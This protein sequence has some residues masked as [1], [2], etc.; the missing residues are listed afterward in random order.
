MNPKPV[1]LLDNDGIL[2]DTE[3]L[4]IEANLQTFAAVGHPVTRE[5]YLDYNLTQGKGLVN[6]LPKRGFSPEQVQQA[7]ED[8]NQ[9]YRAQVTDGVK[10]L[11]GVWDTL[12]KIKESGQYQMAI[13]TAAERQFFEPIHQRTDV[14]S[15]M[16]FVVMNED[17]AHMKPAP[18]AYLLAL[19]KA[20]VGPDE[21][22]VVEDSPRGV[23]AAHAA[24]IRRIYA[25]PTEATMSGDFT[26]AKKQLE[27]FSQLVKEMF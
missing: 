20:G 17:V 7:C 23:A 3:P 25:I 21:A 16:D 14:L 22:V 13:V 10:L 26:H 15:L 11:P 4:W 19:E 24:G 1:L 8:R 18:D 2:V 6:Y 9:L 5:F 12:V 27:S